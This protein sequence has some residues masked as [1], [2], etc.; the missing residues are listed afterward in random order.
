[1]LLWTTE[2]QPGGILTV[3]FLFFLWNLYY[4]G[5]TCS[6]W[7]SVDNKGCLPVYRSCVVKEVKR[8]TYIVK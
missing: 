3:I 4:P 7:R 5:N 6:I 8:T 1:M 2:L